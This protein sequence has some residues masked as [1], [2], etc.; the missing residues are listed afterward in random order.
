[1]CRKSIISSAL[2]IA[3]II[4]GSGLMAKEEYHDRIGND[5]DSLVDC[6]DS[7]YLEKNIKVYKSFIG[8]GSCKY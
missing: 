2:F 1:M 3:I 5:A 7:D 6:G 4:F 8:Y